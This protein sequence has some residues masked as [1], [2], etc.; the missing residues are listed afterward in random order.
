MSL[1]M[2]DV[3]WMDDTGLIFNT[4]IKKNFFV[5]NEKGKYCIRK[6]GEKNNKSEKHKIKDETK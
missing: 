4:K 1:C 3:M 6:T 2:D 5:T